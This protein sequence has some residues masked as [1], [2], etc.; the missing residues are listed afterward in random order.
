[1][2][3]SL[4]QIRRDRPDRASREGSNLRP[5]E[6]PALWTIGHSTRSLENFLAMLRAH[7]IGL[8]VDVRRYPV[9]RRHPHFNAAALA[10]RLESCGIAYRGLAALGGRRP[11]Q[12]GSQNLGWRNAG[13]RGYADYMLTEPFQQAVSELLAQTSRLRTAVLCAEAVPWRCHR[14]LIAD[15]VVSRGW[16]VH[17][18]LDEHQTEPHALSA[19]AKI[20]DGRIT[21]PAT[22]ESQPDLF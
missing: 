10:R 14:T 2:R 11:P 19:F 20:E 17:H 18:I 7:G 9:S 5:T 8:V 4:K 15:A 21:Y 1:M 22:R 16:Q 3:N 6:Q 13:F 12:P